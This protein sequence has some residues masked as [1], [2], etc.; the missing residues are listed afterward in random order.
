MLKPTLVI[1][2]TMCL[3]WGVAFAIHAVR[4]STDADIVIECRQCRTHQVV[5]PSPVAVCK[6]CGLVQFSRRFVF[7]HG[8]PDHA[9]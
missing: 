3:S 4:N 2:A 7:Q 6:N 8:D 5:A 9:E 1:F